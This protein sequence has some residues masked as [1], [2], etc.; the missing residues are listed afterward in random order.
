MISNIITKQGKRI[1]K[2]ISELAEKIAAFYFLNIG[3]TLNQLGRLIYDYIDFNHID[4]LTSDKLIND[5]LDQKIN[6]GQYNLATLISH[7]RP[8]SYLRAI[9]VHGRHDPYE[10]IVW[11]NLNLA[12][13]AKSIEVKPKDNSDET[14][15]LSE[16]PTNVLETIKN[17][18]K[19]IVENKVNNK[20]QK[21]QLI[22]EVLNSNNFTSEQIEI[23]FHYI[24]TFES[25]LNHHQMEFIDAFLSKENTYSYSVFLG[26]IKKLWYNKLMSEI[27]KKSEDEKTG[28]LE[29]AC[30]SEICNFQRGNFFNPKYTET[31]KTIEKTIAQLTSAKSHH[32]LQQSR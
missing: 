19:V 20:Y 6:N 24:L 2:T 15:T 5:L 4:I 1:P 8:A 17:Q 16:L 14:S 13:V 11:L 23:L 7:E 29:Q 22:L 12:T 30:V 32:L 21:Q 27:E 28:M 25:T 31:R 10:P 18:I 9:I 3:I 26:D